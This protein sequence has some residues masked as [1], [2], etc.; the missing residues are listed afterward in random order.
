MVISL[1]LVFRSLVNS[2]IP[3]LLPSF[4]SNQTSALTSLSITILR[5][6]AFFFFYLRSSLLASI[7]SF[8]LSR[9]LYSSLRVAFHYFF[10]LILRISIYARLSV[11]SL[12]LLINSRLF[13]LRR[14]RLKSSSYRLQSLCF[15]RLFLLIYQLTK[16]LIALIQRLAVFSIVSQQAIQYTNCITN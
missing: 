5:F 8:I 11:R 6:L 9:Q 15:S 14:L 1:R 7:W 12:P 13:A 16:L 3:R 4:F 10:L 2:S